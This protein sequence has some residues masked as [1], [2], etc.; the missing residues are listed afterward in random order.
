M[1]PVWREPTAVWPPTTS[2]MSSLLRPYR[3]PFNPTVDASYAASLRTVYVPSTATTFLDTLIR[4]VYPSSSANVHNT[5]FS[6]LPS[7]IELETHDFSREEL[8]EK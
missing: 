3:V 4:T 8:A 7:T 5:P 2:I 6:R 1:S